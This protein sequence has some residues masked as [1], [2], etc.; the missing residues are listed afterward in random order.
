MSDCSF[1]ECVRQFV[2]DQALGTNVGNTGKGESLNGGVIA[3]LAVVGALLLLVIAGFVLGYLQQRKARKKP[4]VENDDGL[5]GGAPKRGVGLEW[6]NLGY[7]VRGEKTGIA[8]AFGCAGTGGFGWGTRKASRTG[9]AAASR[10]RVVLDSVSGRLPPGGFCCILGPSGAGKSTFVDIL[11]GKRK[12]NGVVTGD[13]KLLVENGEQSNGKH[14]V[15]FVDQS[16]ILAPTSTVREALLFATHLRLPENIPEAVKQERANE[17]MQQ[18]GL[19]DVADTRIGDVARRG[20]S[21]GEM[22]RLSI[23]LELIAAP[24]ILILDEPTSGLDSVSAANVVAVLQNLA[25]DPNNPTTIIASI[26]QPS[27]RLYQSFDTV[28]LLSEGK[29]LYFGPGGATPA[30]YF[31]SKGYPCP[32]GYNIADHLLEI[33][34]MSPAETVGEYQYNP[35]RPRGPVHSETEGYPLTPIETNPLSSGKGSQTMRMRSID[36]EDL[37]SSRMSSLPLDNQRSPQGISRADK[38]CATTFLTQ[39]KVLSGREWRNLKRDKSLF[40]AHVGLACLLGVFAGGLYYKVDITISGFQNR[41]GSLFFLGVLLAFMSLSSL[42]NLFIMTYAGFFVNIE[43]IPPVLR[44]LRYFST[45]NFALEALAVNEVNSGLL[46]DDV[47]AG[48]NVQVSASL[49]METLFGFDSSHYYRD[50][51]VLFA[52][53]AGYSG[54]LVLT[55]WYWLRES[56]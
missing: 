28:L 38:T 53:L 21:G 7:V 32:E 12:A 49:I 2:I 1:G 15:G 5:F 18:L 26:H 23:G 25:R 48:V 35:T 13:V 37:E 34:S 46:I 16:D 55:V 50:V 30:S 54:L 41:V 10:N 52:F 20:I 42:Y 3:G 31:A 33:A 45:L 27:S 11:A 22:R 19:G 17:V 56:R 14:R 6:Y 43:K 29:P 9:G 51:L 40:I 8:A 39:L 36:K 4:L 47:L 44:W 24:D